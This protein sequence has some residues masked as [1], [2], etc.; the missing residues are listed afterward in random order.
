VHVLSGRLGGFNLRSNAKRALKRIDEQD[1]DTSGLA[2]MRTNLKQTEAGS[3][4]N[5]IFKP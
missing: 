4:R 3:H 1:A 5:D 2:N